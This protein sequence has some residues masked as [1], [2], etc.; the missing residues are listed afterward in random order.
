MSQPVVQS[1]PR[2]AQAPAHW[3]VGPRPTLEIGGQEGVGPAE[4]SGIVGVTRQND[5]TLIVADGTSRELR[6][7]G[8]NGRYL[9]TATRRGL[10]PGE[11]EYLTEF[12]AVGD[13]LVVADGRRAVHVFAPDGKWLRS[14]IL[15]LVQGYIVNPTI[16]RSQ[17]HRRSPQSHPR[18]H[19]QHRNCPTGLHLARQ[20]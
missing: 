10:G 19:R 18:S 3:R 11:I 5:G 7:F 17:R 14:L 15:P 2:G 8:A 20:G 13:T 16:W 1:Y 4:F 6:F 9:R 12:T